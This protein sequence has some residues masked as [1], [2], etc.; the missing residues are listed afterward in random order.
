MGLHNRIGRVSQKKS[1]KVIK[2]PIDESSSKKIKCPE[3][4]GVSLCSRGDS[5][6]CR[7]C[8]R[9]FR[10]RP[11]PHKCKKDTP[12]FC[13]ICNKKGVVISGGT[14]WRCTDI[15]CQSSWNKNPNKTK[16]INKTKKTK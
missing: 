10:K 5:W 9:R 8:G 3:C 11:R 6:Q 14:R 12:K 2:I 16:K 7:A 1:R 15:D 4:M 13:K